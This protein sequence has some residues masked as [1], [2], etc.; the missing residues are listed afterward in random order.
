MCIRCFQ[1]CQEVSWSALG[2]HTKKDEMAYK[3][4]LS[5]PAPMT[6]PVPFGMERASSTRIGL[7]N[8]TCIS[9]ILGGLKKI[10]TFV[11]GS[12]FFQ[13]HLQTYQPPSLPCKPSS[14]LCGPRSAT[15]LRQ[16]QQLKKTHH[17][18][19][20]SS[21]RFHRVN[22]ITTFHCHFLGAPSRQLHHHLPL[23]LSRSPITST[24]LPTPTQ[25]GKTLTHPCSSSLGCNF[26][27]LLLNSR[28]WRWTNACFRLLLPVVQL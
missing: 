18:V 6:P 1:V 23:P 19:R 25:A 8:H 7:A 14:I 2:G 5:D 3:M 10:V 17:R 15:P 9:F 21:S 4:G 27:F 24:P 22:S 13:T 28:R 12:F 16:L 20:V 26:F 11:L